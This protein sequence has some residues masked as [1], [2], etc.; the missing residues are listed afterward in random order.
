MAID[1]TLE[2]KKKKNRLSTKLL[3]TLLTL[4]RPILYSSGAM[5]AKGIRI[6][7]SRTY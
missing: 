2:Q 6:E 3:K 4:T 5:F 7:G 1:V